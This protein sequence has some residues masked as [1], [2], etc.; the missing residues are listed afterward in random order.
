MKKSRRD[1]L[2]GSAAA[3]GAVAVTTASG[4]AKAIKV[5]PKTSVA[6]SAGGT[7][8]GTTTPTSP[9]ITLETLAEAEKLLA[10]RYTDPERAL[11]LKTIDDQVGW[12]RQRRRVLPDYDLTPATVFDVRA[13]G[14]APPAKAMFRR[15]SNPFRR[16]P[17]NTQDIA[18]APVTA[19]SE[20]IR[21]GQITSLELT[22]LYLD[23]L[24]RIGPRLECVITLTEDLA[25]AQAAAADAEIA[26]GNYRGP[27]HGIPWGAKDLLDTKGILTTWGA[28][29]F[30][31]RVPDRD[32]AVVRLLRKA[33]AV[34]VAKLT[35]G[36]LAYGDVWFGGKTRNPWN[37]EEGSSGSSA[38]SAAA[39]AAGLVGFAIGSE[40]LGSI[41]APSMRCG[42]AGLRPTFGR[43]P[44]TGAMALSYSMDKLGPICRTVEDTALVLNAINAY[45][46]G[47]PGSVRA[48]F[49]FDAARPARGLRLGYDPAWFEGE[50]VTDVDRFTLDTARSL[51]MELVEIE[52]PDLPYD[53]LIVILFAE[54]A[55]AF[56]ELTLSGR[57]DQLVRQ[58]PD[59]WPNSF[60][61]A[62]F[63]SAVDYVQAQRL[64]RRV[65]AIMKEAFDG[66]DAMI[67]PSSGPLL[68]ITNLT[69]HPSLTLRTGFLRRAPR[70]G[71]GDDPG[72][73]QQDDGLA[74]LATVPHGITLWGRPFDEGTLCTIGIALEAELGVWDRR[75][76]V[77]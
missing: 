40:T 12:L 73:Q 74:K 50:R 46:R 44:R 34:L 10:I 69:G 15:S 35:L 43:V 23:R 8:A 77:G 27:L 5:P 32:A 4:P 1:F 39:T 67:S 72:P 25:L 56:E 45:D 26:A 59:A 71:P 70:Q 33:G 48:P 21:T 51:G 62:R 36:A 20:W 68:M 41:I 22:K 7:G 11:L 9:D 29:P 13:G 54:A 18:Y 66:I 47:D 14:T 60:R 2:A 6:G 19:L 17:S 16:L 58:D 24:K 37:L 31:N 61:Q 38:G 64:R 65:M 28:A 52:L 63:I 76:P 42:T 55:A 30:R 75:P 57:D 3:V 53:S 49:A